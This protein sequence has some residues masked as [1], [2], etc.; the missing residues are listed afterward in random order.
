MIVLG[1][2]LR[3]RF[4]L[5]RPFQRVRARL[6]HKERLKAHCLLSLEGQKLIGRLLRR[7]R[8]G[9]VGAHI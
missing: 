6:R 2:R 7:Q 8:P 5:A 9:R 3:L 1:A 4:H